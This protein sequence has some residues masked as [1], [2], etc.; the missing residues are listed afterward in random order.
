M[1][2]TWGR[3]RGLRLFCTLSAALVLFMSCG[4]LNSFACTGVYI[5][6]AVSA[7]GSTIL[8]RTN[9]TQ[10]VYPTY[11]D[12]KERVE[13][14]PGRSLPVDIHKKTWAELP[15]T[16]FRYTATPFMDSGVPED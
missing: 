14:V 4:I 10:G 6:K 9:D 15:A 8:A 7:D 12:I 16:T 2:K 3:N 11:I 5:G 1:I 13:D